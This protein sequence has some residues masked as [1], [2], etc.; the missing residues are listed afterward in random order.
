MAVA[1]LVCGIIG[2]V[3]GLVPILFVGAF[4]LG[5]LALG[6][7]GRG[8]AK[9]EPAVGRK[10]MATWGAALGVVAVILGF[11]GVAIVDDAPEDLDRDLEKIERD[12]DRDLSR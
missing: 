2:V 11:V 5:V 8:R 7:V 4:V 9:R 1:A 3:I 12:L 6:L 10:T